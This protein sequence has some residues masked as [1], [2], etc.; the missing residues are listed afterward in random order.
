[1]TGPRDFQTLPTHPGGPT[2][3]PPGR[4]RLFVDLWD[5]RWLDIDI[6]EVVA[7]RRQLVSSS[8]WDATTL[9]AWNLPVGTV[10]T[11]LAD[12]PPAG[13]NIADLSDCGPCV[14]LIG[15]GRTETLD[16]RPLSMN[17]SISSYF[18]REVDLDL[19]AIELFEHD[20][21][22][23]NRAVI[24]LAE[25]E[26]GTVHRINR[27]YMQDRVSAARWHT[28]TD[29]QTAALFEHDD[30]SGAQFNNIK[31]WGQVKEV[32]S[33]GEFGFNDAASSFRWDGVVPKKEIIAPFEVSVGAGGGT[34]GLTSE[35]SGTNRTTL[36]QPIVLT[37]NDTTSQTIT[38]TTTDTHVV[39]TS[40]TV[41][42]KSSVGVEK[43]SHVEK[44]VSVTLS[45]SYTH[46]DTVSRSDTKTIALTIAQTV[47]VP[48]QSHY[49]ATLL[50]TIGK[51]PPTDYHT[52]AERWYDVPLT[53][54]VRDPANNN[55]W[56]RVEPVTL[57]MSGSLA[58]RSNVEVEATSFS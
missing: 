23:G 22:T 47:N 2:N 30:G 36:P 54:A 45:Y 35:S 31:G 51:I 11:M 9:I 3:L 55:W 10:M 39:G 41:G 49:R 21:F 58:V 17:D 27:W 57:S 14:D 7:G 5:G 33:L 8:V 40:I 19:G 34:F 15:T 20:G 37:L 43:V 38:A 1:M 4:V 44:S 46:T 12:T 48:P 50:V 24:F 16:L 29:R 28:L 52:T 18:W 56:K 42:Y 6:A 26:R 13:P 25:W 32:A 53:G